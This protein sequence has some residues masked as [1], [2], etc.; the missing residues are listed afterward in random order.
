[1][2]RYVSS[3]LYL[4]DECQSGGRE[5]ISDVRAPDSRYFLPPF[6]G[7]P[8]DWILIGPLPFPHRQAVCM[9]EQAQFI[10]D[11][12]GS[13][14]SPAPLGFVLRQHCSPNLRQRLVPKRVSE[15]IH[16]TL[17]TAMAS[18]RFRRCGVVLEILVES[19]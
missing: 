19:S 15:M 17:I 8:L 11:R 13:R 16:Q 9:T 18:R 1:M 5:V 14:P 7:H 6:L 3:S 4:L 10:V 2:D 12:F